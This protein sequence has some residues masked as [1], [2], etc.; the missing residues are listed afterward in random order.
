MAR[1]V[2][3]KGRRG[4][5][6]LIELSVAV[7]LI[8]IFMVIIISAIN[9][10][11]AKARDNQRIMDIGRI[12][13]ALEQYYAVY[14]KYPVNRISGTND[15]R[16]SASYSVPPQGFDWSAW[17]S[18]FR[19]FLPVVPVDPTNAVIS[20]KGYF[21]YYLAGWKKT[22]PTTMAKSNSATASGCT[23]AGTSPNI[24]L[25]C[26]DYILSATLETVPGS[27][28]GYPVDVNIKQNYLVGNTDF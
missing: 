16:H 14:K 19:T 27:I 26:Q 24:R 18:Q 9:T 13:L 7:V 28:F 6:T 1:S 20:S 23:E 4:G 10:A 2:L 5:F 25:T 3:S 17:P 8:G 22:G 21:Y 15:Q 11:R 12:Q